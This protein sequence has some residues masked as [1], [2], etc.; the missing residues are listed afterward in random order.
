ME[1]NFTLIWLCLSAILVAGMQIGFLFVEAGFVRSKNS[2]NVAMKNVADF[3]VAVVAFA[4]IGAAIMFGSSHFGLFGWSLSLA[5]FGTDNPETLAMLLFQAM[6]CGTAATIISGA[7]AERIKFGAYLATTLF[8]VLLIYPVIGH[9][10]WGSA[11]LGQGS[12]GWLEKAGFTDFAGSSVV[13]ITGGISALIITVI[14]GPRLGRF[15]AKTGKPIVIQGHSPVLAAA[16]ALILATGWMGFNTGG[17][18]PGSAAFSYAMANTVLAGCAGSTAAMVIGRWLDGLYRTDRAINGMLS[19]LVAVT[20]CAPY[21][22][23]MSAMLLGAATAAITL[24]AAEFI[25]R[26]LRIDDAVYAISVHGVGGICGILALPFVRRADVTGLP[27][28][29]QLAVQAM[30]VAAI[31]LFLCITI[32]AFTLCLK[33]R[34]WLRVSEADE[35]CGLNYAEHGALLGTARLQKILSELNAGESNLSAR[36]AVDDFDEGADLAIAFNNFL[37]RVEA[38]ERDARKRLQ[39]E[40][41]AAN[42][43]EQQFLRDA[44][45]REKEQ[46]ELLDQTLQNFSAEFGTLVTALNQ[47]SFKLNAQA[48]QLDRNSTLSVKGISSARRVSHE[49]MAVSAEMAQATT[50]LAAMLSQV[51]TNVSTAGQSAQQALSASYDGRA[52]AT[53]LEHGAADIGKLVD[54][55]QSIMRRANILALNAAIEAANAGESGAGFSVVAQEIGELAKQT[56]KSSREIAAIVDHLSGLIGDGVAHFRIIDAQIGLMAEVSNEIGLA[57]QEQ[58]HTGQRLGELAERATALRSKRTKALTER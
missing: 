52:A 11:L 19:A 26:R 39:V 45:T 47:H 38:A 5:S 31:T 20:A 14:I 49:A 13:H 3:A 34:G 8:L 12:A 56:Q 55:I 37:G 33:Y 24:V 1:S 16:G 46:R 44:A 57:T 4:L 28:W 51:A 30:G 40:Q 7:V 29:E 48:E 25:E 9:W 6:F 23:P 36:V 53:A 22:A 2:I 21:T 42:A 43:Q 17:L 50:G 41:A 35:I 32:G 10:I 18:T 54:G 27:L 15:D 58:A